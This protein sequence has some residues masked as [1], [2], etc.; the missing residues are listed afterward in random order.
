MCKTEP[1]PLELVEY[2]MRSTQRKAA[3]YA[4]VTPDGNYAI[5]FSMCNRRDKFSKTLALDI[6]RA[7]ADKWY[8]AGDDTIEF[9]HTLEKEMGLFQAR[10]ARFY[11]DK[12]LIYRLE[13]Q[14]KC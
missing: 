3:L 11:K 10:C 12:K 13:P 7:R 6:C 5:T 8:N 1:K 14:A 4:C 9:P 2:V